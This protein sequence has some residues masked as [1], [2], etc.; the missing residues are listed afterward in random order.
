MRLSC[1]SATISKITGTDKRRTGL[2]WRITIGIILLIGMQTSANSAGPHETV[3]PLQ[4]NT[5]N[6][7]HGLP[8]SV[9]KIEG[10]TI[11]LLFDTGAT[12]YEIVLSEHALQNMSVHYLEKKNCGKTISGKVCMQEFIIPEVQIGQFTLRNVRGGVMSK[13]WGGNDKGFIQTGASKNGVIGLKLLSKYGVLLDYAHSRVILTSANTYPKEYDVRRWINIPFELKGGI[14]TNTTINGL[15]ENLIWDTGALPSI[16]RET[17]VLRAKSIIY[18]GNPD[19][20]DESDCRI[21]KAKRF[22]INKT[23]IPN[24]WFLLSQIEE[25]LPFD[26]FIGANYFEQNNVFFDFQNKRIYIQNNQL[27]HD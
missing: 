2:K 19:Y 14:F 15:S 1:H 10:K 24:N 6:A 27:K 20:C 16:I 18:K 13:L 26:G 7:S 21:L 11:P 12:N 3:L 25:D 5:G 22:I 9:V 4:F 17:P 8:S 23:I